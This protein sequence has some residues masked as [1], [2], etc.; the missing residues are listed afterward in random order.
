MWIERLFFIL[1]LTLCSTESVLAEEAWGLE[2][3]MRDLAATTS[4][5]AAYTEEKYLAVLDEP[6]AV[7]GTLH[8]S[9][10]DRLVKRID[11]PQDERYIIEGDQ[12][13]IQK[14]QEPER[15]FGLDEHPM[16]RPFVVSLRAVMA[17]DLAELRYYYEV[18]LKGEREHWS[19]HLK[20]KEEEVGRYIQLIQFRGEE[21]RIAQMEILEGSGDRSLMTIHPN[22]KK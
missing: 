13:I 5:E 10:P 7:T 1:L 15:T 17:G 12:M 3:L 19:L 6:L 16:I 2:Q 18:V 21:D 9:A 22:V 20:P 8:Y 14:G 4:S 11:P